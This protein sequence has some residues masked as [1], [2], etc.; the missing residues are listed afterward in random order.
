MN[1]ALTWRS[2]VNQIVLTVLVVERGLGNGKFQP[3]GQCLV[4][5]LQFL[6]VVYLQILRAVNGTTSLV[7]LTNHEV[8]A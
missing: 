1:V 3:R 5:M 8:H 4:M 2:H 6:I 7:V